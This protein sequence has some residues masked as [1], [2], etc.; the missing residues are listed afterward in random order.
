M[1]RGYWFIYNIKLGKIGK[2]FQNEI[3]GISSK[4]FIN[5]HLKKIRLSEI[6]QVSSK[7]FTFKLNFLLFLFFF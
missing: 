6:L 4:R 3:N 1:E 5:E 2:L 7:A